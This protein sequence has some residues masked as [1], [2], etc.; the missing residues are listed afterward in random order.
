MQYD[1]DPPVFLPALDRCVAGDRIGFAAALRGQARGVTDRVA[2]DL[3]R[4]LR[5]RNRELKVR[6]KLYIVDR[7]I[8]GVPDHLHIPPLLFEGTA[9]PVEQRD[10]TRL[11]DG[12]ARSEH[13]A[14]ADA[15]DGRRRCAKYRDE[16]LVDLG[17]EKCAKLVD[18]GQ[19]GRR[20][21][22]Y[23]GGADNLRHLYRRHI[24]HAREQ[25]VRR[26]VE[27]QREPNEQ[28][29]ND[30]ERG[31]GGDPNGDRCPRWTVR[32]GNTAPVR[33]EIGLGR[34]ALAHD[35]RISLLAQPV[36]LGR[37]ARREPI[38]ALEAER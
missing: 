21:R 10:E 22:L 16:A 29:G 12:A 2:E 36:E 24:Q 37:T 38:K 15:H 27:A 19:N 8:V 7:L 13:A 28:H 3:F 23:R 20:W 33:R 35:Q 1:L 17:L 34:L 4:R 18:G 26:G 30:G 6:R 31:A 14:V 32:G 5:T 9:D 25:V 11:D